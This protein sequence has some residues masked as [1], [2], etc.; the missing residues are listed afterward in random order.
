MV[1]SETLPVVV[2]RDFLRRQLELKRRLPSQFA[3]DLGVSHP[4]VGRWLTGEDVPNTKCCW[5]IAELTGEPLLSVLKMAGH[6]PADFAHDPT[7]ELP[8]FREYFNIK[9]PGKL[10]PMILQVIEREINYHN[11]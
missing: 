6:L 11:D 7:Y 5:R 8:A 3:R 4:T 10:H 9:Y 1:T 2:L